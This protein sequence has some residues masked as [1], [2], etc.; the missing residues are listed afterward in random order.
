MKKRILVLLLCV[1]GFLQSANAETF[2]FVHIKGEKYR[3]IAEVEEKVFFNGQFGYNVEAL[4]KIAVEIMEVKKG[5]GY[6]N[7]L[8]QTSERVY[9]D[10][11]S[12]SLTEE[13]SSVFWRDQ[14]GHYTINKNYFR[15]VF[16]DIPVF[17]DKDISPG[18]TWT[19]P[20]QEL[21]DLRKPFG[22]RDPY[23]IP[24]TVHYTYLGNTEMDGIK[25]SQFKVEYSY[26]HD[27]KGLKPVDPD[28]P[29]PVKIGGKVSQVYNWDIEHGKVHSYTD[30]F[31][32][33][34]LLSSGDYYEI[35]GTS[36]GE[37]F[38]SPALDR[39]KAAEEI[40]KEIEKNELQG[41]TVEQGEKGIKITLE[42]IQFQPDSYELMPAEKQKL[43]TIAQILKKYP[44]RDIEIEGHAA[45][46]GSDELGMILSRNRAKA[47]G[48][49][50][51]YLGATKP[52]KMII[53][54]KGATEPIADNSTE[55][56]RIK[57]RR[58]EITIL[59]N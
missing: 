51:L 50:L 32:V 15:P 21:H 46:I 57:N 56:G 10:E 20:A 25:I 41:V 13:L 24:F 40:T 14:Q 8:Y 23:I 2:R 49:Y 7:A 11:G 26:E 1:T 9:G 29:L 48:D 37:A 33:V 55:A 16:R 54:G 59:E 17:P 38:I 19:A 43:Q 27:V 3:L 31:Y 42:N 18:F 35:I 39:K 22:I 52:N 30:S 44:E 34:Y 58:V 5:A 12:Y 36:K 47:V 45:K 4:N 53:V 28:I 6:I